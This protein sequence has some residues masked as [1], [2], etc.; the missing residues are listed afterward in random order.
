MVY[1]K[2]CYIF[3]DFPKPE[4]MCNSIAFTFRYKRCPR[5]FMVGNEEWEKGKQRKRKQSFS[6]VNR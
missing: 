5:P 6:K 4:S 1:R 2:V 3:I